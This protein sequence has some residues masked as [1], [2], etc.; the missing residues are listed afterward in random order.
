MFKDNQNKLVWFPA[1]ALDV[2]G[3]VEVEGFVTAS[4][5]LASTDAT[6]GGLTTTNELTIGGIAAGSSETKIVVV[7]DSG[8]TAFRTDLDLKGEKGQKG[9]KGSKGELGAQGLT[10]Q[11]G[12]E[13]KSGG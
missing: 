10:G 1:G 3:N 4:N 5:I 6:I 2:D 9:Q 13:R 8:G 11:K 12:Q 7:N